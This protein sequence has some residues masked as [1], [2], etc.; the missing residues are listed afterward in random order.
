MSHEGIRFVSADQAAK[1]ATME[2]RLPLEAV[3]PAKVR[4]HKTEGTGVEI[5]WKDGHRSTW[6]F[7][8]LRNAC[9]C[10]TCHED[11]EQSGR[12]PGEAKPKPQSL[13]PMYEAPARPLEITPV[14]KY[15]V[16]FKWSDGHESG[17][18]SWE[19]LRRVCQC[20]T[21]TGTT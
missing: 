17:I 7:V 10:A 13:L 2:K 8:W 19:Y 1:E 11:R 5:D 3:T 15:A 21:C 16:K 14:G 18:Y 12:K 20:G 6:N 9:P 4:I